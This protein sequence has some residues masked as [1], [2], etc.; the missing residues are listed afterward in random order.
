MQWSGILDVIV[1]LLLAAR[2]DIEHG[3]GADDITSFR[4][5]TG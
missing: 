5:R 1:V 4:R 3:S 2:L